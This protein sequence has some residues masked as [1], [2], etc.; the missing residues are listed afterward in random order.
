MG[1]LS[2]LP[3]AGDEAH[4]RILH[5]CEG[6]LLRRRCAGG[7]R[8][9]GEA[10]PGLAQERGRRVGARASSEERGQGLGPE[11]E[12]GV[13]R[14]RRHRC[15]GKKFDEKSGRSCSLARRN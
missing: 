13:R 7:G 6:R 1:Y 4:H 12:A 10:S 14:R 9:N 3:L 5:P 2:G 8:A 11:E 15:V